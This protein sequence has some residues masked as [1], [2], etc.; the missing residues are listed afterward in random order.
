MALKNF[1]QFTPQ[2]LLSATDFI[3]G[4]RQL[5]EIRTDLSSLTDAISGLLVA[6]GFTPGGT[7]GS[8]TRI[9]YRYTIGSSNNLNA[10]S[11]ADD[12]S[13]VLAYVPE[14]IEVYRNGSHLIQNL[15]FI[16]NNGTQIT[17]LSTM[18]LGD[19]VEVSVLSGIPVTI[20]N[21]VSTAGD[22]FI[23]SYRYTVNIGNTIVPGAIVISGS[24]DY[25]NVLR[26]T[27]PNLQVYLNGSQLIRDVDYGLYSNGNTLTL[28]DP[29]TSGDVLDI[30]ALS[31]YA[32]TTTSGITSYSNLTNLNRG[33][34]IL[35]SQSSGVVTISAKSDICSEI[36]LDDIPVPGWTDAQHISRFSLLQ[37]YLSAVATTNTSP[38]S[39]VYLT[40]TSGASFF[41]ITQGCILAPNGKIYTSPREGTAS[42]TRCFVIDPN[43]ETVTFFGTFASGYQNAVLAPN[44]KIYLVPD[45]TSLL[46]LIDP[47][48]NTSSVVGTLTGPAHNYYGGVLAPNGKIYLLPFGTDETIGVA[49]DPSN[50]S[51]QSFG[52]FVR[53]GPAASYGIGGSVLAPNGKIYG[54]PM[55][56]SL[57]SVVDPSNNS[58]ATFGTF[59]G[60]TGI[61]YSGGVLAPNGK[62]YCI[63]YTS[64]ICQIIDPSNNTVSSFGTFPGT[65]A[66]I[67]GLLAPNGLIYCLPYTTT[68][69]IKVID[70][71]NNTITA[72]CTLPST[73]FFGGTLCPNGK[74][75]ISSCITNNGVFLNTLLN[76]N[77]NLNVCTN[78]FFN[79]S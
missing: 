12:Y 57:C 40:I 9:G 18:N 32:L 71:S 3:V 54:M 19:V 45:V 31:G 52:T 75:F 53:S 46:T 38:A 59:T 33:K 16:A 47:S 28:N 55:E 41:G 58:I 10:V 68:T 43:T 24:D 8:V 30:I 63:P 73:G 11:G 15:D 79:K 14:T 60:S 2:T 64:T 5:D 42:G 1:T 65:D 62:I 4:Y 37:D 49:I 77:F 26:F 78:P 27:S 66:F 50:N 51:I 13:A 17:N 20:T 67:G 36:S 22:A 23:I 44:G 7:V 35:V 74:I 39:S 72:I 21:S 76:N 6:K 25:S 61:K 56:N 34:N 48:N 29:V 70:P 69:V